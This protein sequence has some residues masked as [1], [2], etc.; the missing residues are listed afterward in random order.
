MIQNWTNKANW[1][2]LS[3]RVTYM[4]ATDDL[5]LLFDYS[6]VYVHYHT[7]IY[8]RSLHNCQ[9]GVRG[10]G[11]EEYNGKGEMPPPPSSMV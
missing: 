9:G 10:G 8:K 6:W 7:I 4:Y 1:I 2:T 11:G 5:M 3:L